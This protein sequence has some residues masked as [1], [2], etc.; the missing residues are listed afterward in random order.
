MAIV[1]GFAA[2]RVGEAL[3]ATKGQATG[4]YVGSAF[5]WIL[6]VPWLITFLWTFARTE[7]SQN[8]KSPLPRF[9]L[10]LFLVAFGLFWLAATILEY[11]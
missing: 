1:L 3:R 5:I 8:P 2:I 6:W 7:E 10:V 11:L 4:F 9:F